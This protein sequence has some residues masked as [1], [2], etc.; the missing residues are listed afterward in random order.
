MS[1]KKKQTKT[2]EEL[3]AEALV[4]EEEQPYELPE[5]WVWVRLGV[6]DS[7]AKSQKYRSQ[8]VSR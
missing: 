2:L 3:L 6:L 7:G 8:E 4:P 1:R 5:N